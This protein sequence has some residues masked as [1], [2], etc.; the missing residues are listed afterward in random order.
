MIYSMVSE[1]AFVELSILR[2]KAAA[3]LSC[4]TEVSKRAQEQTLADIASDYIHAIGETIQALQENRVTV[5][6]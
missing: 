4:I 1:D 3:V 2:E 6:Q 5:P